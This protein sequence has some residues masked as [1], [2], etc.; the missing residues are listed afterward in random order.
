MRQFLP[1]I[2]TGL[3]LLSSLYLPGQC[4][5]GN[6][7]L[8]SQTQ[9]NA[10]PAGCPTISGNL[11]ISEATAGDII[12]LSPLEDVTL[13]QGRLLVFGNTD[14]ATLTG[15]DNIATTDQST[16]ITSNGSLTDLTGLGGLTSVSSFLR[17]D[18]NDKLTSLD[19]LNAS[20][21]IDGQ[22]LVENNPELLTLSG[23]A[24]ITQ[25]GNATL[26]LSGNT[27]LTDISG[28]NNLDPNSI[29]N[30]IVEGNTML[31]TCEEVLICD[32]LGIDGSTATITGNAT[33]CSSRAE[34]VSA[35][36]A[37]PVTYRYFEVAQQ[38]KVNVLRWATASETEN[39]GFHVQR[40][41]DG[42]RWSTLG[43]V[44][45][46]QDASAYNF[47]HE[48][49]ATGQAY[50]R[51]EQEDMDGSSTFSPVRSAYR[52]AADGPGTRIYPNPASDRILI[53]G[54]RTDVAITLR[55][56]DLHG[57]LLK[58]NS[59]L[60]ELSVAGLKAGTYVVEA[61]SVKGTERHWVVVR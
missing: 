56:Y 53:A 27:K 43:F 24:G 5:G 47:V 18:N 11:T 20:L 32:Y 1:F 4:P 42:L 57:R 7:T 61:V 39:R 2:I 58:Q 36:A 44:P 21:D 30:L 31:A 48:Q 28:L 9:I 29:A 3:A 34:V 8:S 54:A 10:F 33:G 14:L 51:L 25:I 55:L 60:R 35:C 19:G 46:A 37:L 59:G 50:Y 16:R 15:L 22:L 40:S 45:A 23:L 6:I 38:D 41:L 13:V 49:P 52:V 17:I 26:E 12:D